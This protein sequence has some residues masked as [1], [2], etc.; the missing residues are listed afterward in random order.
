[1]TSLCTVLQVKQRMSG[2]VPNMGTDWDATIADAIVDASATIEEEVRLVRSQPEGWS[3]VPGSPTT[4]RYT[5][6]AGGSDL[7]PIDDAVAVTSVVLLDAAGNA[8]QTLVAGTDYL[9]SPINSLPITGL[10]RVGGEWWPQSY[11]GV[12][13][14]ITPGYFPSAAAVAGDVVSAAIAETIRLVRAGQAGEDDR[15]GTAPFGEQT[16]AKALLAST[17]RMVRRY[18]LGSALLRG[19]G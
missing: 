14:G 18:R 12:Q 4:R 9:P 11:G 3:F 6:A 1:M 10:R 17:W 16:V 5:G 2:D 15:L 19:D 7:L 8:S 13:V